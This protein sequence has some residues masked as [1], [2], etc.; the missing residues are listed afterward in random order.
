[1]KVEIHPLTASELDKVLEPDVKL[2]VGVRD[3]FNPGHYPNLKKHVRRESAKYKNIDFSVKYLTDDKLEHT[4]AKHIFVEADFMDDDRAS[5]IGHLFS[6]LVAAYNTLSSF[7]EVYC[8]TIVAGENDPGKY[9]MPCLHIL[10]A[11][12]SHIN[13]E[14][15]ISFLDDSPDI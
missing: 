14:T 10:C 8:A 1:M 5:S 6:K 2:F 12:A 7:L 3:V 15:I 11:H 4:V 9:I 13:E